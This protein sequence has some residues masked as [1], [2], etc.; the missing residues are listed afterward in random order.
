MSATRSIS[1]AEAVDL[2][3]ELINRGIVLVGQEHRPGLGA[4]R[5][6]LPHAIVLLVGAGELVL[7]D[8]V[9]VV[10]GHAGRSDKARLMVI[11]H[12]QP[13]EVVAG[14]A[15]LLQHPFRDHAVEVFL[16]LGVDR[17]V[18]GIGA[19]GQIDLGLGDVEEAPGLASGAFAGLV[20]VEHVIGGRGHLGGFIGKGAQAGEG[21]NERHRVDS[22]L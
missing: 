6:D 21:A 16:A 10:I 17:R 2:R 18:V 15:V 3:H 1:G 4:E 20:A 22:W 8:A 11:A 12:D 9:C 7:A 14:R 19:S 5:I 13:V